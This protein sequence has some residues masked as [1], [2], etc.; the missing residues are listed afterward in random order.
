MFPRFAFARRAQL[1]SIIDLLYILIVYFRDILNASADPVYTAQF[2]ATGSDATLR[3]TRQ[4]VVRKYTGEP[5]CLPE[6]SR[7]ICCANSC[8]PGRARQWQNSYFNVKNGLVVETR[9]PAAM[10]HN[11][12]YIHGQGGSRDEGEDWETHWRRT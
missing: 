8:N 5:Q 3:S 2:D 1:T 9:R 10:E 4:D 12:G 11:C 7:F 6:S